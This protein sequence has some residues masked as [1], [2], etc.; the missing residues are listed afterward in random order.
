[1]TMTRPSRWLTSALAVAAAV[2]ATGASRASA[3]DMT[4]DELALALQRRYDSIKDFSADFVHR[5][6]G[7]VLRKAVSERGHVLIKKPGKMR[8]EYT[9]PE[10]KLFVADG[11][12]IF[13]YLPEDK[14]V[15]VSA[16][17]RDDQATAPALFLAGKGNLTRDFTPSLASV[18]AGSPGAR[19]LKLVPKSPQPDYDWLVLTLDPSL[20]I[21][22]LVTMDAQGG[23]S[24]FSFTNLQ[25][26]VGLADRE[27]AFNIPRG[28]DV[29]TDA[30]R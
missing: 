10:K 14:Q 1:M 22:G 4:A 6:Q 27:F 13:S 21:V 3:G 16:A 20:A 30:Q 8:W 19:A 23:Q 26:N 28:V 18:P 15:M 17:P 29:I 24:A 5:Y 7:G 9:A 2:V 25:E 12:R 11:V